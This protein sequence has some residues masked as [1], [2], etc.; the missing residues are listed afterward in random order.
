MA[1]VVRHA[2]HATQSL[3]LGAVEDGDGW[4]FAQP[5]GRDVFGLFNR[6][7]Q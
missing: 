7:L 6:D 5:D 3:N 4:H 2:R 1:Q